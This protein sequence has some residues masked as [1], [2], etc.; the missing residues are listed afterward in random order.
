V[1]LHPGRWSKRHVCL[2]PSFMTPTQM[3]AHR[4]RWEL[5]RSTRLHSESKSH[6][7]QLGTL[8]QLLSSISTG[9][10]ATSSNSEPLT[11]KP[12]ETGHRGTKHYGGAC[13]P[14][15]NWDAAADGRTGKITLLVAKTQVHNKAHRLS[16]PG[17]YRRHECSMLLHRLQIGRIAELGLTR[18]TTNGHCCR[19]SLVDAGME[20]DHTQ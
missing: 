19:I 11:P 13:S 1:L 7:H 5:N 16:R 4:R 20:K 8:G 15:S 17:R 12:S 2:L 14:N 9:A 10:P 6:H 18:S 3:I